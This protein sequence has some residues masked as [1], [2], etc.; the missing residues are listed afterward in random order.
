MKIIGISGVSRAGKDTLYQGLLD[1]YPEYTFTRLSIAD[2]IRIELADFIINHTGISVWNSTPEEKEIYRPLMVWYGN[3]KR[4]QTQ[5]KYF[6]DRLQEQLHTRSVYVNSDY[7][8][9][10][11]IRFKEFVFDEPDWV[12]SKGGTM[13]HLRRLDDTCTSIPPNNELE[14]KNDPILYQ[15]SDISITWPTIPTQEGIV[16]YIRTLELLPLK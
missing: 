12:K 3:I 1:A 8:V 13:I 4:Q 2:F 7:C 6:L 16:E 5:G 10:T 11:D 14:S 9:I 15:L